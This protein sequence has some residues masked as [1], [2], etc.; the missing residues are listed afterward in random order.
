MVKEKLQ[1]G[2]NQLDMQIIKTGKPVKHKEK[3]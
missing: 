1:T 2:Y 3:H